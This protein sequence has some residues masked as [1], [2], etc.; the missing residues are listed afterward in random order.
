MP[1]ASRA[2]HAEAEHDRMGAGHAAPRWWRIITMTNPKCGECGTELSLVLERPSFRCLTC[3]PLP[4]AVQDE[5]GVPDEYLQGCIDQNDS[6]SVIHAMARELFMR[7][8]AA[9]G[10]GGA[11]RGQ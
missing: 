5:P 1:L 7:R 3:K 4:P 8:K 6:D 2:A 9:R 11:S 10:R